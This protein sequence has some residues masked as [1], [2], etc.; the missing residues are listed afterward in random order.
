MAVYQYAEP[1]LIVVSILTS[2]FVIAFYLLVAERLTF[3]LWKFCSEYPEI[4]N[5]VIQERLNKRKM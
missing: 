5:K 3:Y 4:K 1:F 2:V